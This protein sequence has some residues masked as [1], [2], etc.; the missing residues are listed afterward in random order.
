MGE[1]G[2]K[3]QIRLRI[4]DH[5]AEISKLIPPSKY[6]LTFVGRYIG[7]EL[8][9]ADIV[10]SDDGDLSLVVD[11]IKRLKDKPPIKPEE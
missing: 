8:L 2:P 7:N 5:L 6:R 10:V 11:A 4:A 9:D 1:S 3:E